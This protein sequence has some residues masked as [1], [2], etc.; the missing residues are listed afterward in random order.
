MY[1][2]IFNNNT[3]NNKSIPLFF[4]I[5]INAFIVSSYHL[6]ITFILI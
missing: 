5:N 2:I 6:F 1:I 4:I 3:N